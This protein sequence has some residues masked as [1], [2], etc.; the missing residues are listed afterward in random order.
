MR[1]NLKLITVL[2]VFCVLLAGLAAGQAGRRSSAD[3]ELGKERGMFLNVTAARADGSDERVTA[4]ELALYDGGTEQSIQSFAPDPSPARIVILVDNSLGL[5]ADIEKLQKATRE[6]AYEIYEGD[7]VMV[8]GYDQNAEII[9]DWTDD[10]KK[11][12][13]TLPT[14][15]KRGEP[16]LF[17]ALSAVISD[18]LGPFVAR[19]RKRVIVL[20][21]DG[22]DRG[23]RTHF[24]KVFDDLLRQDITVYALQIPDRTGGALRRDSLKPAQA[25]QKLTEGTGGRILSVNDSREAAKEICDEL[26]KRRYVLA[27]TPTSLP[28]YD[29]RRLL[30]VPHEGINVRHKLQQPGS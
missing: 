7:Q 19:N 22:L 24:Q 9:T 12:E 8:I 11:V 13:A 6:F 14:F 17:D 20:V 2:A 27:Y 4:K 26:R 10:A 5:R 21:A 30:I 3:T 25:I 23:S 15:R 16:H 28:L 1:A 29:A 18:A